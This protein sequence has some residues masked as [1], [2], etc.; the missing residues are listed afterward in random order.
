MTQA[1]KRP[2]FHTTLVAMMAGISFVIM[3]FD[4]PLPFFPPYLKIDFSEIPALITAIVIGPAAGIMVELLKNILHYVVKGSETGIPVGQMANFLAGSIL[5]L[6]TSFIYRRNPSKK[7]LLLGLIFGSVLM[8]VAMSIANLYFILPFYEK[9]A[10]YTMTYAQ[11]LTTVLVGI[12]PF[13][14]IKGLIL[15]AIMIPMYL[16]LKPRLK[17]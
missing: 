10:G 5:V 9:L 15:T 4:F 2:L 14:L 1:R 11:R 12:G 7:G 6:G 3:Y 16:S 13:N 8:T 17:F